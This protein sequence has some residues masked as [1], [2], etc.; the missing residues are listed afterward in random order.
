MELPQQAVNALIQ[1]T[2]ES[3]SESESHAPLNPNTLCANS[4]LQQFVAQTQMLNAPCASLPAQNSENSSTTHNSAESTS[5]S[6]T[7]RDVVKRKRGRPRKIHKTK[8]PEIKSQKNSI[9]SILNVEYGG[10][11]NVSPDSGI[12]NSPDHVS[13][14]EP[15]PSPNA[16]AK[17]NR[18]ENKLN[19]EI[20]RVHQKDTKN[21]INT[22]TSNLTNKLK[23]HN[24]LPVTSNRF[25]RVLYGNTDRVL[26]PPRR[27]VGR[28]PI[29]RK[30]PGRP[31]K[32]NKPIQTIP[33][34][35]KTENIKPT[36]MIKSNKNEMKSKSKKNKSSRDKEV[37]Q[38]TTN[39]QNLNINKEVKVTNK[40]TKKSKS[41][42]LYEICERVSK[43]LELGSKDNQRNEKS[44]KLKHKTR[45]ALSTKTK[46]DRAKA[47]YTTLKNAKLMHS[48][49]KHKKHKKYKF[50]ILKP[51]TATNPDP[52]I[53]SEIEKLIMD[54][55]KFCNISTNKISKENVPEM[56]KVLKKVSKKRKTSDVGERKKKKQHPVASIDKET[57][58][59]QRLPLKKR[60]YHLSNSENKQDIEVVTQVEAEMDKK[61]IS[62]KVTTEKPKS[63]PVNQNKIDG[64]K[65]I[66]PSNKSIPII[67]SASP[68][69]SGI[70]NNDYEF[71][72][73]PESIGTHI[74]EAIEACI[75][76][77]ASPI[78][79]KTPEVNNVERKD[80]INTSTGSITTTPKKRHRLE[81]SNKIMEVEVSNGNKITPVDA[82][83]DKQIHQTPLE[84]VVSELKMKRNLS[85]KFSEQKKPETATAHIIT[86][87]KNRLEDLTFNLVTKIASINV[88]EIQELQQ[89]KRKKSSATPDEVVNRASV[90]KYPPNK[91]PKAEQENNVLVEGEKPTGIF[92]PTVDLELQ[93]SNDQKEIKQAKD[94]LKKELTESNDIKTTTTEVL[95]APTNVT[96][97]NVSRKRVRKRRAI[98]RT[99]FPTV[100]KKKKKIIIPEKQL[101]ITKEECDRVP[102][103]G[104]EYSTFVERTEKNTLSSLIPDQLTVL[105]S[106][107]VSASEN[108]T[109]WEDMSECDSLPLEE[110]TDF[111]SQ[112]SLDI[113][114]DIK[115]IDEPT[116]RFK[117]E[118]SDSNQDLDEINLDARIAKLKKKKKIRIKG[119]VTRS[120][121]IDDKSIIRRRLRDVSPASS[122][123]PL[124]DKRLK[125]EASVSGDEIKRNKKP[126]RW[127]KKYLVAGL[128]S[129]YYKEDE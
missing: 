70:N 100:K 22:S 72:G 80:N 60:H 93:P 67:K 47:K 99:G 121:R 58:N 26:Y 127:R 126:P 45:V 97:D 50:K 112:D 65:V 86:R 34:E 42:L 48:K 43:R 68:K 106:S 122:I 124:I 52:K 36:E 109:K 20:K 5:T 25:D 57:N 30:G 6:T 108:A 13:S 54:F 66:S 69:I 113:K 1:R 111:E 79:N 56:L 120:M 62:N 18:D 19:I 7:A 76:R 59:E 84:N 114:P 63:I 105:S 12:Q 92:T 44:Q 115:T 87:K 14:P 2:T 23:E 119:A 73:N 116:R 107:E 40:E 29:C 21:K 98:N 96:V 95:L 16:K 78:T 15:S 32:H 110:R 64:T 35:P 31:P 75:N 89:N 88:P 61:I 53:N 55:I 28:P 125:E 39:T 123:E 27:K 117:A 118:A 49:H 71:D 11:P 82:T 9:K 37:L 94:E 17:F 129:D 41:T 85:S 102:K 128:F 90:I 4:L 101:E 8:Q 10:D 24:K 46:L 74:D 104:E 81:L 77:Y 3:S 38:I 103:L 51:I 83:D 91:K 33:L